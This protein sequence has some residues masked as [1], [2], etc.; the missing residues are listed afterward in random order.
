MGMFNQKPFVDLGTIIVPRHDNNIDGK[1]VIYATGND[2]A[3][4]EFMVRNRGNNP[5]KITFNSSNPK[6][7]PASQTQFI[8]GGNG[9]NEAALINESPTD[10]PC[11]VEISY[12]GWKLNG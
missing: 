5:V 8:V 6:E 3:N 7:I 4:V 12:A 11:D 2:V 10:V 1:H 9:L